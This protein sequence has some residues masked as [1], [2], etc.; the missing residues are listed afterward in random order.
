[1]L[2]FDLPSEVNELPFQFRVDV[3][4]L[5]KGSAGKG[6]SATRLRVQPLTQVVVLRH[7]LLV[8]WWGWVWLESDLG[9]LVYA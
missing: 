8:V 2:G 9:K 4:L 5:G 3:T 6:E 1:M 7:L